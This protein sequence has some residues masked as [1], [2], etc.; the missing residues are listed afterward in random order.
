MFDYIKIRTELTLGSYNPILEYW[1]LEISER[2]LIS[3]L[4]FWA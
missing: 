4:G 2:N 1:F 3:L